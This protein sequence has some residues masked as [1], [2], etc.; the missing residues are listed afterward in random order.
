M[1]ICQEP[2]TIL[3]DAVKPSIIAWGKAK[4]SA[5]ER[6]YET[7]DPSLLI[8]IA[9]EGGGHINLVTRIAIQMFCRNSW[10]GCT[11]TNVSVELGCS[12]IL[13]YLP[14]VFCAGFH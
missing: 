14:L 1:H 11:R 4:M 6:H 10:F 9:T 7:V 8:L 3:Q 12:V 5:A 13:P 2:V